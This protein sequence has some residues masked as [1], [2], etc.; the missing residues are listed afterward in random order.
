[1]K[2]SVNNQS[3]EMSKTAMAQAY[4]ASKGHVGGAKVT[5]ALLTL[6][7]MPNSAKSKRI[8]AAV[9]NALKNLSGD[10]NTSELGDRIVI[11]SDNKN[12]EISRGEVSI[13]KEGLS[14]LTDGFKTK[15]DAWENGIRDFRKDISKVNH[16]NLPLGEAIVQHIED[17][18]KHWKEKLDDRYNELYAEKDG[19][20]TDI[21]CMSLPEEVQKPFKDAEACLEKIKNGNSQIRKTLRGLSQEMDDNLKKLQTAIE[22]NSS[23]AEELFNECK[24]T[25]DEINKQLG[26]LKEESELADND[27]LELPKETPFGIAAETRQLRKINGEINEQW[28]FQNQEGP[29]LDGLKQYL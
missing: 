3:Y 10:Q 29:K 19:H 24:K 21:Y 20:R 11:S 12:F 22:K 25:S 13:S 26:L 7:F 27:D 16:A 9:A 28:E 23:R 14:A 2:I 4:A 8:Q 18:L 6:T 5:K 17:R 15:K 1:M